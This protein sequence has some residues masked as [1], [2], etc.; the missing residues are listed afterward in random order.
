MLISSDGPPGRLF[1]LVDS[2]SG[3]RY[4]V[5]SGAAFSVL[6]HQSQEPP[7]GPALRGADG[8]RINCWGRAQTAVVAQGRRFDWNFLQAAVAFPIL[9][10]DF[11]TFFKMVLDF[12]CGVLA[13]KKRTWKCK[14]SAPAVAAEFS[15]V[16]PVGLFDQGRSGNQ[17]SPESSAVSAVAGQPPLQ[18]CGGGASPA[19]T[20]STGALGKLA[21]KFKDI[22]SD[23]ADLPAAKHGVTHRIITDGRPVSARYRRLD[24]T[25]LAAAKAEFQLLED[26]GIVRRSQSQW[27]SPLHMVKKADGTWRP[28]GDYRRLNVQTTPDRYTCPHIG[29]L[30]ARLAGCRVFTKLDLRKGYHQVPVHPSDI[31]KTAVIT[32]FGLYEYVRMPFGLRNAGQT[33]QR[34]MDQVLRG[35]DY[36]FVYLDDVLVAS[37]TME[38]HLEQLEVV[39]SR[40]R[41]A[42]LLLNREK[43]VFGQ[44]VVEF[45]GH[46][47]S[48][49]GVAPLQS[50]VQAVQEFPQPHTVKQLM[51]FLG[52]LNFYR[53]FLPQAA[54]VLKPLTDCL[55]GASAAAAVSW[56]DERVAAFEAAKQLL[57]RAACLAHPDRNAQLAVAVDAS[58][59][60]IGAVLQQ[61]STRG[62]Q[63]LAFFSKKLDDTQRRYSTFDRELLACHEAVR[64]FRWSLEGRQFFILTD[65]KPLTFALTRASDAWSARQQRQLAAIAEY[66]TDIRHVAGAENVVADALSR[67]PV[68]AAVAAVEPAPGGK[69]DYAAFARD[70]VECE[71]T[72]QLQHSSTLQVLHVYVEGHNLLCDVSTGAPRPLVPRRWRQAVFR[73]LHGLSHPGVKATK[74]LVAA[75]FVWRGCATDVAEW[76]RRCTG[77]ARGKPGGTLET[78]PAAIP[79]PEERFSHVH[80]DIVGPLPHAPVNGDRQ[81]HQVA[82]GI[83]PGGGN[84]E[85]VCGHVFEWLGG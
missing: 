46:R 10:S 67:P 24:A 55:K 32:P 6:P 71:D 76:C 35:L 80:V 37:S 50:K 69:I 75:R 40:L 25:K 22:F 44:P 7:R 73:M 78:P 3:T 47:V 28:C 83:F 23:T 58:D 16:V 14:L 61:S 36:C 74:R 84:G 48:A 53:R 18:K 49:A 33:F 62:F 57:G 34:L 11:L 20:E 9:G 15:V 66:T 41:E 59:S 85:R 13:N 45:L 60:H 26:A 30:T 56:T 72:V 43:C 63:P 17:E 81:E 65:H 82:R 39:F 5:D 51:T 8:S 68:A 54:K 52:M 31:E 4:L 70:Q 27:A 64:H 77:C 38:E 1:Y 2:V 79:I 19:A 21:A 29:D 12:E 42:G